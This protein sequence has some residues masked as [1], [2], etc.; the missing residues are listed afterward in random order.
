MDTGSVNVI[1]V[2]P[3]RLRRWGRELREI[4]D[5]FRSLGDRILRITMNAPNYDGQLGPFARAIGAEGYARYKL[6]ADTLDE[7]SRGLERKADEFESADRLSQQGLLGWGSEFLAW[8]NANRGHRLLRLSLGFLRPEGISEEDWENLPL[9][10]LLAALKG[11]PPPPPTPVPIPT[12]TP[13]DG[14]PAAP[15]ATSPTSEGT[16][17]AP[18]APAIVATPTP[19]LAPT[20]EGTWPRPVNATPTAEEL[21]RMYRRRPTPAE[22]ELSPWEED[23]AACIYETD[24]RACT[25]RVNTWYYQ[26]QGIDL[27]YLASTRQSNPLEEDDLPAIQIPSIITE[28][29]SPAAQPF[30]DALGMEK[31]RVT[32]YEPAFFDMLKKTHPQTYQ[33]VIDNVVEEG[34]AF[35]LQQLFIE[36]MTTY[37]IE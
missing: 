33:Y 6:L 12:P 15:P 8:I 30:V 14:A 17:V 21:E 31:N 4:A 28:M 26:E 25:I 32:N 5:G 36:F 9:S 1:R 18:G 13:E 37:G 2:D 23:A 22:P 11:K 35:V 29:Q 10:E 19:S 24:P 16:P 3:D 20:P 7:L 34:R 27:E